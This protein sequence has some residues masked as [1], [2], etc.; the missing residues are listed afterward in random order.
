MNEPRTIAQAWQRIEK[1]LAKNAPACYANLAPSASEDAIRATEA[2]IGRRLPDDLCASLARHDGEKN[3]V[4][5]VM[6][7]A[8]LALDRIVE[9]WRSF[10]R[11][12]R[13]EGFDDDWWRP[14]WVPFATD[15]AGNFW[16]AD[17]AATAK[18]RPAPIVDFVHD[19]P[20][21]EVLAPSFT[22]ILTTLAGRM[23]RDEIAYDADLGIVD[24]G[25]EELNLFGEPE[26]AAVVDETPM[27][28]KSPAVRVSMTPPV[29][30]DPAP[31][32]EEI[33]RRLDAQFGPAPAL[34][35]PAAPAAPAALAPSP[36]PVDDLDAPAPDWHPPFW[37][38]LLV[39]AALGG[40]VILGRRLGWW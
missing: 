27:R 31:S 18:G 6:G 38:Q 17:V 21:R 8:L 20:D 11:L 26:A 37:A 13:K 32:P 39:A 19:E 34:A 35:P 14:D 16:C 12:K 5:T 9:E 30:L 24:K 28:G 33:R 7:P 1:W 25:S 15:G 22:S 29:A 10:D 40:L 2:A 36:S 4:D 3:E 23:E